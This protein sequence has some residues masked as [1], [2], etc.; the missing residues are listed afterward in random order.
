LTWKRAFVVLLA[1][2]A[3]RVVA[4]CAEAG[5]DVTGGELTEAGVLATTPSAF[6][7]ADPQLQA[8]IA[9]ACPTPE[10]VGLY[11]DVFGPNNQPGSC[12]FTSTCHGAPGAAG[13]VSGS[14]IECFDEQGCCASMFD[15][16]LVSRRGAARPEQIALIGILRRRTDAGTRGF[17][18]KEPADYFFPPETI[19]RVVDWVKIIAP[20]PTADAGSDADAD[21]E[22]AAKDA[23]ID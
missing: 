1:A 4:S 9:R 5:G 2:S 13:A 8:L 11:R 22:D 10:W 16:G 18:P 6:D 15:K 17:M 19:A 23:P 21:S 20:P 14:G 12:S 3:G 7:A